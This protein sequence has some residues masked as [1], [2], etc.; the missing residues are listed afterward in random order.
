MCFLRETRIVETKTVFDAR[1]TETNCEPKPWVGAKHEKRKE[2]AWF[3][4]LVLVLLGSGLAF[5][6][7][8]RETLKLLNHREH[9]SG[10]Y[11]RPFRYQHLRDRSLFR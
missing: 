11:R 3:V 6:Q 1:S 8:A 4:L 10:I 9:I 2:Y 5:P 7:A